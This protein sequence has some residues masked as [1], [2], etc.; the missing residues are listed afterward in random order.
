MQ[1]Q[2]SLDLG[3]V[4]TKRCAFTL[5]E[6]LIAISIV[7]IIS[8]LVIPIII[9]ST[10]NQAFAHG[11]SKEIATITDAINSLSVTENKSYFETMMYTDTELE[12]YEN[13]SGAFIKKYLK[14]S[15]YCGSS[16]KGCFADIYYDYQD[17]NKVVYTPEYKGACASLKNGMSLCLTPQI[18]TKDIVGLIDLNGKRE[19]N[20]IGRDLRRFTIRSKD[21]SAVS[22]ST[23]AVFKDDYTKIETYN[24]CNE[25][26]YGDECCKTKSSLEDGDLCC[27][28]NNGAL[29]DEFPDACKAT[30]FCKTNNV[31]V[32]DDTC[33]LRNAS[34]ISIATHPCC[35]HT[36]I[37]SKIAGC[38]SYGKIYPLPDCESDE[39][40][41]AAEAMGLRATYAACVY[42]QKVGDDGTYSNQKHYVWNPKNGT[43][44]LLSDS[45]FYTN[46]T[47]SNFNDGRASANIQGYNYTDVDNVYQKNGKYYTYDTSSKSFVEKE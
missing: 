24:A 14:I 18:G 16:G 15:K 25:N 37:S 27:L 39:V 22:Q 6:V 47:A 40:V 23:S 42:C 20:V 10:S 5:T 26:P 17:N 33:C 8:A 7:G 41:A 28:S 45:I 38:S 46:S 3:K 1:P 43:F 19:P 13:T 44:E 34:T 35:R 4:H 21:K 12:D 9:S 30:Y 36:T 32:W 11:L 29:I 2:Y 31:Q